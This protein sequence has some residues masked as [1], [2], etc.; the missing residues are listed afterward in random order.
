MH[1]INRLYVGNFQIQLLYV[2]ECQLTPHALWCIRF[3]VNDTA[4]KMKFEC[5]REFEFIIEKALAP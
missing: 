3:G 4:C 2:S 5:L 1:Q